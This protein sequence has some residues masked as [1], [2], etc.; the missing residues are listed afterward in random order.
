MYLFSTPCT[1]HMQTTSV[2]CEVG[3]DHTGHLVST[4]L[5]RSHTRLWCKC[6]MDSRGNASLPQGLNCTLVLTDC[7]SLWWV[8]LHS[9]IVLILRDTFT[10]RGGWGVWCKATASANVF[11]YWLSVTMW[12][13]DLITTA[14]AHVS[15]MNTVSHGQPKIIWWYNVIRSYKTDVEETQLVYNHSKLWAPKTGTGNEGHLYLCI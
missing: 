5:Q 4:T 14:H 13:W 12:S 2:H 1:P 8:S 15:R 7:Y 6:A 9:L 3:M 11:D 10:R